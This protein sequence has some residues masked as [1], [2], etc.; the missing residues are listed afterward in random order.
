M[1]ILTSLTLLIWLSGCALNPLADMPAPDALVG[2]PRFEDLLPD[3]QAAP[4]FENP[5]STVQ[6]NPDE[7]SLRLMLERLSIPFSAQQWAELRALVNVQPS[8]R[9]ARSQNASEAENLQANYERFGPLFSPPIRSAE[10]YRVRALTFAEKASVPHYLD[11]QYL[12]NNKRL[13]LIKW[14][15]NTEEFVVKQPDGSLANYLT[16]QAITSPRYLKVVF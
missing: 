10:D 11:M 2:L 4:G 1:R 13:L 12:I 5:D 7:P 3:G 9:W 15:Q 6:T 16:T 14:D 8:G